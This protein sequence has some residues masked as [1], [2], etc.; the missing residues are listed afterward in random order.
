MSTSNAFNYIISA[1]IVINTV[2]L[3]LDKYP[4][5][6]KKMVFMDFLNFIFYC[7]FFCEML[8]K[9]LATGLRMYFKDNYN[10]FDFFVVVVSSID[11]GLQ[12]FAT[13][14]ATG[15]DAIQ[16]LRVF[17]LLRVFKLAK[18]WTEFNYILITVFKTLRKVAPFS[19]LVLI[20][21]FSFTILGLE[22]FSRKLSFDDDGK[23]IPND[24]DNGLNNMRGSVPDWNFNTFRDAFICVFIVIANDGWS[25]IYYDH[26]RSMHWLLPTVFFILLILI[27]QW[28]LF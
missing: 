25:P 26:V 1:A 28:V 2:V 24:Y 6:A 21:A 10:T 8:I 18:V 23:P 14:K 22:L 19:L 27:G 3:A 11:I 9:M 20:V 12:Q 17:R 13:N 7:I 4:N 15:Y 16:A 5:D